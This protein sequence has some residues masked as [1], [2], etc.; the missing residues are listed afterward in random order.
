M[1]HA[2]A[3]AAV[4][5]LVPGLGAQGAAV[6]VELKIDP[7]QKL[8]ALPQRGLGFSMEKNLIGM[9]DLFVPGNTDFIGCCK[10]LGPQVLRVGGTHVDHTGWDPMGRFGGKRES[11]SAKDVAAFAQ[12]V[13]MLGWQVVYGVNLAHMKPDQAAQEAAV[14]AREL[15]SSLLAFEIGNE[16]DLFVLHEDKPKGYDYATFA[17]EWT[18]HADAINAAMPN[19][20][21]SGPGAFQAW[22]MYGLPFAKDFGSRVKLLTQHYYRANGKKPG[23]TMDALLDGMPALFTEMEGMVKAA[24][25][26]NISM[27]FRMIETNT[28]V[29]GGSPGVSDTAV[30]ALWALEYAMRAAEIGVNGINFQIGPESHSNTSIAVSGNSVQAVR[31]EFYGL[32]MIAS[33]GTGTMVQTE[34]VGAKP[35]MSAHSFITGNGKLRVVLNNMTAADTMQVSIPSKPGE[36]F[37]GRA[38]WLG[39]PGLTATRGVTLGGQPIGT[40]GSGRAMLAPISAN[41]AGHFEINVPAASAVCVTAD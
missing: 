22:R 31:P 26:N 39:T 34:A 4:G 24:R 37:S 7:A 8:G 19:A 28:Y 17:K 30:S 20:P 6:P 3:A 9:G 33:I 15:G 32:A 11:V 1:R 25:E 18:A 38:L 23:A 36:K 13:K 40:N 35:R 41:T 27:G 21:L 16:P 2:G 14:A 29:G 10:R 12:F 5:A